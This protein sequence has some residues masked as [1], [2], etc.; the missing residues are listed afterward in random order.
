LNVIND[1]HIEFNNTVTFACPPDTEGG[2]EV[3]RFKADLIVSNGKIKEAYSVKG[4][5]GC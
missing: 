3:A 1:L 2:Y 5:C 4:D